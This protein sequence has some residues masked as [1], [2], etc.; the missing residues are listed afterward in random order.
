MSKPKAAIILAAGK[1]KRMNSDL[2]KVL[3]EINGRPILGILLDTLTPLGFERICVVI[4]YQGELVEERL[5]SYPVTFAW[6][7]EQHGTGHAVMMTR[8]Q[9]ADFDG[10]TLVLLGDVPLLTR[11]SIEHLFS[12][13]ESTSAVATCLTTFL[14]DPAGYG[15]IVR[16]KGDCLQEIVED[17]DA[18]EEIRKIREI[19][20]GTFCFDNRSLFGVL[21]KLENKNVQSE[22]Y[23]TDTVK[24]FHNN[25]LRVSVA[26]TGNPDEVRGIN[27]VEQLS[28]LAAIFAGRS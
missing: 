26:V 7:R 8:E 21:D 6:Q 1:G 5:K 22:Y 17:R 27:S 4:G 28:E 10:T 25:G 2:P 15:R 20:S 11:Q 23:L 16:G 19:N 18:S 12:V 3:H 13:H 14:G 9:M 24:I